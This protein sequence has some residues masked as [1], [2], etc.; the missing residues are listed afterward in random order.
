MIYYMRSNN[1]TSSQYEE[2]L[3]KMK[4]YEDENK[5]LKAELRT[6]DNELKCLRESY[7]ELKQ[8]S[9]RECVEIRGIPLPS[10]TEREMTNDIVKTVTEKM[11]PQI[12][13]E[14][15]SVSHRLAVSQSRRG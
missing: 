4:E 12:V 6:S 8:Y 15:V 5:S 2:V 13:D 9:R 3:E 1:F 11:V 14:D 10:L 7:N